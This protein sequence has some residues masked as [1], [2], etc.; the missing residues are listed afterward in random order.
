MSGGVLAG[1]FTVRSS[2]EIGWRLGGLYI[3]D[4]TPYLGLP[5]RV[6]AWR[7]LD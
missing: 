7:A 6:A 2:I 3:K 1:H 5:Y 4:L